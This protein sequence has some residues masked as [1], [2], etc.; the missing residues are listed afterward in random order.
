[1]NE[2]KYKRLRAEEQV[3]RVKGFYMHLMIFVIVMIAVLILGWNDIRV[4]FICF[5]NTDALT[6]LL[7]FSPWALGLAIH[8][9]VALRKI[10]MF[11][12][13]E[14]RKMRQFMDE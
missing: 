10:P 11:N 9:M 7:S 2:Q 6:N 13:W 5:E 4:C 8:G 14:E 12:R 1:M 3:K